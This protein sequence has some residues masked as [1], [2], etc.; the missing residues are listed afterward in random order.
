M[1][2][3]QRESPIHVNTVWFT[4]ISRRNRRLE[5]SRVTKLLAGLNPNSQLPST[6]DVP[7]N[8]VWQDYRAY[9]FDAADGS[10][11]VIAL[12]QAS[13]QGS[14]VSLKIRQPGAKTVTLCDLVSGKQTPL[15]FSWD[16]NDPNTG[17]VVMRVSVNDAPQV[18]L[19]Q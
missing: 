17:T 19:I 10:K 2:V 12:W 16:S 15:R 13:H 4:R 9:R 1:V 7:S 14:T 5:R 18:L 8:F 3:L 6:Y 11:A